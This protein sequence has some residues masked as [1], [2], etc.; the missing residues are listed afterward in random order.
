MISASTSDYA[1]LGPRHEVIKET[2]PFLDK[3]LR[4]VQTAGSGG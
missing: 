2:L 1:K 3:Y 4:A